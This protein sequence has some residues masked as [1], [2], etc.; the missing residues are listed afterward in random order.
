MR[1]CVPVY[2]CGCWRVCACVRAGM[3]VGV[4]GHPETQL[5]VHARSVALLLGRSLSTAQSHQIAVRLKPKGAVRFCGCAPV[6]LPAT[7]PP[8]TK[9]CHVRPAPA[10]PLCL[11]DTFLP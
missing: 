1:V 10:R 4:N 9:A 11:C 3:C 6:L 8:A 5:A 2:V 7:G